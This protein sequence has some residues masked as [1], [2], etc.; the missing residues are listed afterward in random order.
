[1]TTLAKAQIVTN[2]ISGINWAVQDMQSKGRVGSA[3][4]A[5]TAGGGFSSALN[6]AVASAS[7]AGLFFAVVAGS[8]NTDARNISPGS[9][10]AACTVGSTTID[11]AKM[12]S[13][14]YG[15][16]GTY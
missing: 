6:Q 12:S 16:T 13:S 15:P 8:E 3:T 2:L 10:P 7:N 5:L 11:D 1:M 4:A 14:N 9:E